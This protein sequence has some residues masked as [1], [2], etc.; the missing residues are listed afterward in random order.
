[1]VAIPS[2]TT[3]AVGDKLTA[4][5]WNDD[6]KAA[7]EFLVA[8][9]AIARPFASVFR[10]AAL[11]PATSTDTVVSWDGETED[12]D[13][14]HDL[15]T[16][17]TRMTFKTAGLYRITYGFAFA[18]NASGL[19]RGQLRLNGAG[20]PFTQTS[21]AATPANTFSAQGAVDWRMAANDYVE[22]YVNQT[23]GGALAITTGAGFTNLSALWLGQ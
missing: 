12:N 13:A 21:M 11:S 2:Q 20:S 23:S 22:L 3:V 10:T 15:V 4:A 1:V 19:R 18:A 6:V 7:I 17:P 5:L 9:G 16:N 14:M 8:T